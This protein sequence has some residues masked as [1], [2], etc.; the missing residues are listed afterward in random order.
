M[1]SPVTKHRLRNRLT[2]SLSLRVR[3]LWG[4]VYRLLRMHLW[5]PHLPLA[6]AV[7][8]TGLVQLL[9]SF[10]SLR[11]LIT[12]LS[13]P[14]S[15]LSGLSGGFASL[16]IHGVSREL[17]GGLLVLLSLGLVWRSRLAWALTLLI[18][19]ATVGLQFVPGAVY[20]PEITGSSLAL[21]VLLFLARRSF[22]RASLATGTLFALIG[23]LL[24]M[25]FG[26]LGSYALG[27]QFAPPI[28]DFSSALY[29]T[30]VTMSTV[31]Y[32]DITPHTAD[33]RLFT[34]ALIVLGLVVFATSLTAIVG[35]LIN[36]RMMSLLQ[37]KAK[38]MKRKDHIIVV[39]DN[40]LARNAITA[41]SQR[42]VQ[43]TAVWG[44]RPPEGTETPE[45]LVVGDGSDVEVLR[46]ADIQDARAI[47]ALDEDDSD[48][49][50]IALAA[51]D[52]NANVRTV[53]AVSDAR[54][55]SRVRH[56]RPDAVLALPVIGGELLAMAL[57]GEEIKT[58]AL[59]EQLLK[60]G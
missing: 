42:G 24:T 51:K 33:A 10:G 23:V 17:I 27:K 38:K 20:H 22:Q 44:Q 35:P 9:P 5:F 25:G 30:V 49:A 37:P 3:M 55:M 52:A 40:P 15:E 32:G 47:L 4:R 57:S 53:V 11:H 59:L 29:F 12:F 60:L 19:A 48:N 2:L 28:T 1:N 36:Q 43:V 21:L 54:N 26:V 6:L 50:F 13:V 16:A 58:D 56:V 7:G 8:L 41:L 18:T 39:G 45:D 14:T 31:G 46:S 34:S